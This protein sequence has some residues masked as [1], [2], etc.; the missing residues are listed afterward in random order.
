MSERQPPKAEIVPV[1]SR[2]IIP[3]RSIDELHSLAVNEWA[4]MDNLI[5]RT[6]KK[7]RAHRIKLG[8]LLLELQQRIDA[9]ENGDLCNFWEWFD[10]MIPRSRGDATR[11][12]AIARE[13]DPEAAYQ[14]QLDKQKEYTERHYR[15]KL[16]TS[17]R[18]IEAEPAAQSREIRATPPQSSKIPEPLPPPSKPSRFPEAEGDDAIIEEIA[19]LY[20][21]LSWDGRD[22]AAKRTDDGAAIPRGAHAQ[23]TRSPQ[24]S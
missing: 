20:E 21:R 6:Q 15:K 23:G 18:E 22:K 12:M 24:R 14:R 4:G 13:D 19:A 2:D 5:E 10:E 9:G 11:L 16:G 17:S 3:L 1:E 7:V 8:H